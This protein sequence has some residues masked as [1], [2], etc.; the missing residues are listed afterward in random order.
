M[1]KE[2]P[3]FGKP[4]GSIPFAP[5]GWRFVIPTT[6]LLLVAWALS[7]SVIAPLLFVLLLFE[8]N[9]FRDPERSVPQG[10][11]L[12]VC[13]ADGK[14][15]RSEITDQGHQ[16]VD[17]FM[18]VFNVHV[19]RAPLAGRITHMQYVPGKFVNASFDHASD[20]NERNRFEMECDN[21]AKIAFTQVSGLLARRIVSYV[22]V[23]DHVE[24]GQRIGMIR[25]GSRV[26]CEIPADYTLN[27]KVGDHVTAG[28]TIV[29]RKQKDV[30]GESDAD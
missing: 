19:N 16:R 9:F 13:P 6:I 14:V 8:L 21:G 3:L 18:N 10:E 23:G 28:V 11:D 24:A 2:L 22:E 26:N 25:F 12:F 4:R 15:I 27:V 30:R 1:T 17:I 5:E 7:W 29:A 20:E